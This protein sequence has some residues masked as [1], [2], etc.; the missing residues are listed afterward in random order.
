MKILVTGVKGQ[1][2]HDVVNEC[3][4]RG[5]EAV[6]VDIEEMDI[7]D[8]QMVRKVITECN[9]DFIVHCSAYTAVDKA[10]EDRELC[11]NVNALGTKNI[12]DMCAELDIGLLYLST[13]YVFSGEGTRPWEPDDE[14]NPLNY[15]GQTKFEG[16][17]FIREKLS[18]YYIVRISWV[19][20]INGNNFV[21][22]MLKLASREEITVVDDQIG[23]PTYTYDLAKLIM[24]MAQTDKYGTYHATNEGICSWYEFACEIFKCAGLKV[25]VKPV[26]SSGFAV[27]AKR[28][29]NSRMSKD[30]LV[31]NGFNKLP[32]WQDATRR[33]VEILTKSR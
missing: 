7:T 29:K 10:E 24:D 9:P 22:T 1:L 5:H 2:G 12:V 23:S 11:Y 32:T 15:Y 13:D 6:G 3:S 21:K 30:K 18:K 8:A 26:D 19:F 17:T 14:A 28:P 33:Y 16:E 31:Q 4:K 20:G 27:K 25:N